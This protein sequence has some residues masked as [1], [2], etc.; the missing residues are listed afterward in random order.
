VQHV[1]TMEL[2]KAI[3]R[4]INGSLLKLA[5]VCVRVCLLV[6]LC[7]CA[8]VCVLACACCCRTWR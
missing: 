7:V 1:E 2:Y 5:C 4:Y 6:C 3:V 8:C